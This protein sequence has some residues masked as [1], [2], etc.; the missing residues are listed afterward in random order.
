M[1]PSDLVS[2]TVVD[3]FHLI[4]K[5]ARGG[6]GAIWL[7]EPEG[8]D[9]RFPVVMKI[10]FFEAGADRS[11]IVSYE[12]ESL[13]LPRLSG[14]HLP[15]VVKVG[16][17]G[18]VPYIVMEYVE[19]PLLSGRAKVAPL[20]ADE[21]RELGIELAVAVEELHRQ[22]VIHFDLKPGNVILS[23]R[24]AVLVDFGLARHD[25]LPDLMGE[26]SGVPMGSAAYIAPEQVLGDRTHP[27]SDLFAIGVML[28]ELAT[29]E[30]PFGDPESVSG[31]RRRLYQASK[32]PREINRS[33]PKW[34]Q[35]V[36]MRCL[37]V[38]PAQRYPSAGHL[39][40]HLR[41]PDLVPLTVRSMKGGAP[42]DFWTRL[43][44]W[45][46]R[47]P[48]DVISRA[49]ALATRISEAPVILVSVDLSHG[50]DALAEEV[51]LHA[52]RVLEA[53][54][55]ARLACVTVLKV[56][57]VGDDTVETAEG[58]SA[59]VA[60][61]LDLRQWAAP[62][63]REGEDTVSFH[64]LEAYDVAGAILDYADH[65]RVDHIVIGA[66]ASGALRRHLGSVSAQVVA[67]ATCSVTVARRKFRADE[68]IM[69]IEAL[70][71]PEM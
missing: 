18:S 3:G 60:R 41:N 26:E 71:E 61:L 24:G 58:R 4:E 27:A 21:V 39:L 54:P 17:L 22:H 29:G 69:G 53:E 9:L 31:M 30:K 68:A 5:L 63:I 37:E 40:F 16:D 11:A 66:R 20:A 23:Q 49:P 65:N 38:D 55:F 33:V 10:P 59:Y 44:R 2:G 42:D 43:R 32:P 6:M 36:I 45:V 62:L 19:G 64:V 12:V 15:R 46:F 50:V 28:Y 56:K 25:E 1:R 48:A 51:R 8:D 7:V 34:L 13:I 67:Q 70:P 47:R 52:R 57:L 14:P 35:E